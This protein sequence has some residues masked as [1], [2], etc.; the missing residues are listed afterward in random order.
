MAGPMG[1]ESS[2]LRNAGAIAASAVAIGV[3]G[4]MA[5]DR[6]AHLCLVRRAAR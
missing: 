1:S 2:A 3:E 5:G 4:R 6:G